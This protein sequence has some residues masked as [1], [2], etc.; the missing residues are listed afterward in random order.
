MKNNLDI[1]DIYEQHADNVYHYILFLVRNKEIAEDLTQETF[2]RV[3]QN[4]GKFNHMAKLN[5]W[6]LQ[7]AKN[8]TYDYFRAQKWR[9]FT[10][11]FPW[12]QSEVS[13]SSE[14]QVLKKI[15]L[16]LL[17]TSLQTLKIDYQQVIILRKINGSSINE[18]AI[19]LGW[20]ENKVKTKLARALKKL[21]VEMEKRKEG[22]YGET[23]QV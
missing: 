1:E 8:I 16:E 14:E 22:H 13:P 15:E 21:N 5:T 7:I 19:I 6:I 17:Y 20:S 12:Q 10:Q 3:F 23:R 9:S 11:Y 2:I 4:Y 18:T